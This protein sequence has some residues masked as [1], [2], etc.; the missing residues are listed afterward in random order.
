MTHKWE[1]AFTLDKQSWG[2]RR[3]MKLSEIMTI[4]ELL[5]TVVSTVS[6][7]GKGLTLTLTHTFSQNRN[8]M[9]LP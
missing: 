2:Y 5:Q 8:L 4:N 3:N 9:L 7:G 6:C 1:N